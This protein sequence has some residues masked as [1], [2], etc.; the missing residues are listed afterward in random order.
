MT[1]RATPVAPARRPVDHSAPNPLHQGAKPAWP[2][3][4]GGDPAAGGQTLLGLPHAVPLAAGQRHRPGDPA[5]RDRVPARGLIVVAVLA[6]PDARHLRARGWTVR[7][8]AP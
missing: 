7:I 1:T 5:G 8:R 6:L 2:L 4:A 3:G